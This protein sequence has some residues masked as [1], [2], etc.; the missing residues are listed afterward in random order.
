MADATP[1]NLALVAALTNAVEQASPKGGAW[2]KA[3]LGGGARSALATAFSWATRKV[4]EAR[5]ELAVAD[6]PSPEPGWDAAVCAR[7]ALLLHFADSHS[8][9]EQQSLV[10]DLFYRG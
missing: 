8:T 7:L 9:L 2:L 4:G 1:S 10:S 5:L 6:L 3:Q